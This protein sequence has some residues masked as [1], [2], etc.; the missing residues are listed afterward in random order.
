MMTA[1][2]PL[3]VVGL[4]DKGLLDRYAR[5]A[6]RA[7][8]ETVE[9]AAPSEIESYVEN[10]APAAVALQMKSEG[11]EGVCL[12]LRADGRL[13]GLPI[14][15]LIPE[16]DDLAFLEMYGWGGDDVIR[17][18]FPDDLVPRLRVLTPEPALSPL[19]AR[20]EALIPAEDRRRRILDG[21]ILLNARYS[22]RIAAT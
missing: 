12:A 3:L 15:G 4:S 11:A 9:V 14:V 13:A 21:P 20:G 19:V 10:G 5:S 2:R 18:S 8:V 1:I 17:T 22:L 7:G 6:V 16:L